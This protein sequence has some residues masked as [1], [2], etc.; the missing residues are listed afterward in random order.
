MKYYNMK[1]GHIVKWTRQ[2]VQ[3]VQYETFEYHNIQTRANSICKT[4]QLEFL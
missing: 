3:R 4:E 2:K 1:M